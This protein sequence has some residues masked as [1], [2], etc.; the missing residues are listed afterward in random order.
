MTSFLA[1]FELL[2]HKT[3]KAKHRAYQLDSIMAAAGTERKIL[4]SDGG[5]IR[6]KQSGFLHQSDNLSIVIENDDSLVHIFQAQPR[7]VP[8]PRGTP[9]PQPKESTDN[10]DEP[11]QET[12]EVKSVASSNFEK[13][14]LEEVPLS[15]FSS[16]Y[17]SFSDGI[18]VSSSGQKDPNELKFPVKTGS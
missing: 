1:Y 10:V 11:A 2:R 12:D 14:D 9:T 18:K 16:V 13:D 17:C 15:T 5:S 4:T 8:P 6:V 3:Q 7:D